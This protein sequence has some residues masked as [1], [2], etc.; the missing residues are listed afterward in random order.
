VYLINKHSKIPLQP[1]RDFHVLKDRHHTDDLTHESFC[2]PFSKSDRGSGQSLE[3]T[4]FQFAQ[5]IT[6]SFLCGYLLKERT[7]T[8]YSHNIPTA[9]RF[10]H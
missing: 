6:G 3:K 7:E 9:V 5:R 10:I 8:V 2:P 4:P 1:Q